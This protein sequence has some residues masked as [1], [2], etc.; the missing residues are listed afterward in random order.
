MAYAWLLSDAVT[1]VDRSMASRGALLE[2]LMACGRRLRECD[3]NHDVADVLA[4]N[5]AYDRVLM[6]L[7]HAMGIATSSGRFGNSDE[8]LR[9][10]EQ[11][12]AVCASLASVDLLSSSHQ[13]PDQP[14]S[15]S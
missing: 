9:L 12:A 11:L 5:F 6:E 4:A 3:D 7:A 13:P 8:R 10:E 2:D 1:D 14:T 15:L